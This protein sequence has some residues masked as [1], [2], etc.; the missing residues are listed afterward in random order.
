MRYFTY[1]ACQTPSGANLHCHQAPKHLPQHTIRCECQQQLC[2]FGPTLTCRKA[3]AGEPAAAGH[4]RCCLIPWH[5]MCSGC[6]HVREGP[7]PLCPASCQL[8]LSSRSQYRGSAAGPSCLCT[9]LFGALLHASDGISW[10]TKLLVAAAPVVAGVVWF[11]CCW[12]WSDHTIAV[13]TA[14]SSCCQE[15]HA[16]GIQQCRRLILLSHGKAQCL[17]DRRLR[18]P[19][20]NSCCC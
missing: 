4:K 13:T 1:I 8:M 15:R 18:L 17:Q 5:S 19:Q 12:N 14:C 6:V 10:E 11:C 16:R 7:R 3:S 9:V 2:V 20:S